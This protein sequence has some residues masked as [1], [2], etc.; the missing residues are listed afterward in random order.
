MCKKNL[1][2][3]ADQSPQRRREIARL[4]GIASGTARARRAYMKQIA[5]EL[6]LR[7]V[8]FAQASEELAAEWA[9]FQRWRRMQRKR[10][11]ARRN[12]SER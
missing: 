1:V 11:S 12:D 3:L 2:S 7:Q 6:I 10:K 9:E 4:G 5:R 8:Y